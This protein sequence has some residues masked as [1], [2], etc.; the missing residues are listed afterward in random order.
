V[1]PFDIVAA[2]DA[3]LAVQLPERIDPALNRWC[4]ALK[5]QLERRLGTSIRDLVIGYCSL[6][7]YF[8]PLQVDGAWLDQ[9]IRAI[10]TDL[11]PEDVEEGAI[12]EVPV[13]YGGELGPDLPD[14]AAFAG[15]S[16]EEVVD[17][18]L[19]RDYR[20]YLVGFVPG[21]AYMAEVDPRIAAPR[22]ASPRTAVPAGSVAI[23][24]GQT[25]I[26]PAVTPGG[27]NIVGRTPHAPYDAG[28]RQPCLFS[29]GDRVR[30][31]RITAAEYA[32]QVGPSERL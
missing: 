9:E 1:F 15:C 18:H 2:G 29:P 11:Q 24:G 7:V 3:A 16:E 20:V 14:V 19:G 32:V 23:A 31:H 13:C 30:F 28:R 4:V 21:F 26:Y 27:W 25:G 8:D 5:R 12:V 22:R 10:G 17:R 6:T